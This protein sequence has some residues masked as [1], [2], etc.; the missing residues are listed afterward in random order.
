VTNLLAG[1]A[2]LPRAATIVTDTNVN[3][4][5]VSSCTVWL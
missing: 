1:R 2:G 4:L 3:P 5:A